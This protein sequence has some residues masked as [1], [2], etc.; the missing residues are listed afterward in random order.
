MSLIC[1]TVGF[2]RPRYIPYQYE[3]L[4]KFITVPFEYI[5]FDN[6]N[7]DGIR[8]EFVRNSNYLGIKYIRVPQHIHQNQDPSSRAGKSLDYALRY[9][10]NDM[11][12]RGKVML[13]DS[14]LFLA[15]PYNPIEKLGNN[16]LVGLAGNKNNNIYYV[17]QFL[18]AN[19]NTLPNINN[20]SFLPCIID[21]V[22]YDCGG[23]TI[24]YLKNNPEIK[25]YSIREDCSGVFSNTNIDSAPFEFREYL[26]EEIKVFDSGEYA[27]R[28]F[29]E[30]FDDSFIHL[31]AGSNWYGHNENITFNRENNLFT[32]LCN[33]LIDWNLPNDI[34]N[35]YIIAFAL[36]G[37][38]PKYTYNAIINTVLAQ[39]LYRGWIC[40]YYIDHTVPENIVNILNSFNNVEIVRME[41]K[42]D[43]PTGDKMLWRFYPASDD[44]VAAM[45]SRDCDSWLSFREACSVKKWIESDKQFHII[46]DHCYHSQK[47]MGG[48]W[49]IKRGKV[50]NMADLCKE[51]VVNNS[52]DQGFL[53]DKIYP[54]ILDSV[55]VHIGEDQRIMGGSPSNGYFPD[56][57][58]AFEPYFRILEYIPTIDIERENEHNIFNCC[59]CGKNHKFFIGEMFNNSSG[60]K[61]KFLSMVYGLS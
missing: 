48:M 6:S 8:D 39:K 31:R 16:D 35:K 23:L 13:N 46:R 49:G 28:A 2:N 12:F 52:Y 44:T 7:D 15:R 33:K 18:I 25:H 36:Y 38:N 42:T 59:H 27:N 60:D 30:I 10:Y 50:P 58:K 45:I 40:R 41:S 19:F 43:A 17:N 34:N 57:G 4:K 24:N 61:R 29:S 32:F 55:M 20:L 1:F 11:G 21:G 51:F 53:A 9:M 3:C 47:I 56:G 5:L 14:D 37:N 54:N 26:K 22:N